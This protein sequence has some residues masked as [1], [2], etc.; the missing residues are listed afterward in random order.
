MWQRQCVADVI[1]IIRK[2]NA[3]ILLEKQNEIRPDIFTLNILGF[4]L[5]GTKK[6]KNNCKT[7][8]LILRTHYE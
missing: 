6:K 7:P 5:K 8:K 4:L 1:G 3:E 2:F